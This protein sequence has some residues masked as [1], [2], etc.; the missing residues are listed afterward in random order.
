VSEL[1]RPDRLG[2]RSRVRGVPGTA[3]PAGALRRSDP[4][5]RSLTC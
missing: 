2:V 4:P 1:R 5:T 3:P